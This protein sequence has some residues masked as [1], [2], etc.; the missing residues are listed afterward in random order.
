M[1]TNKQTVQRYMEG[2]NN[3]DHV[4][5]LS[6]LK[7]DVIWEMPGVYLHTG[8][9]AFDKEINNEAFIGSP[10]I[11]NI[12]MFEESDVVIA[13]GKVNCMQKDGKMM[14]AAFCDVFE[15]DKGLISKLTSYVVVQSPTASNS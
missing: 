9:T 10:A 7:E 5:I 15:M 12:R 1:T 2:F 14:D 3:S 13:E 6:C 8:K 4:K 11:S